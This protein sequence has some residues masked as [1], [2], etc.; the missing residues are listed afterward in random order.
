MSTTSYRLPLALPRIRRSERGSALGGVCAGI[1]KSLRV[2][3]TLVRLTFALL[4]FAAGAGV[5]AYAGAWLAISPEDGPAPSTRR[6]LLGFVA[7]AVAG[8][9]ALRGFGFSDSLIWPAV[10][11]GAG[12]VLARGRT[13]LG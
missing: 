4:A 1:G 2:D 3:P 8:A 10:L 5:V 13:V 6:Q 9:I 7:L 12:I 11:C